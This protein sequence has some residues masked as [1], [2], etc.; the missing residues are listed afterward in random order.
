MTLFD[1]LS[2]KINIEPTKPVVQRISSVTLAM[3]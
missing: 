1:T 3:L 2:A